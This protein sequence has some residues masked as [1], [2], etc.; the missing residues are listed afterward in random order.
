MHI[1]TVSGL[2]IFIRFGLKFPSYRFTDTL[3][4]IASS[5][6][7]RLIESNEAANK[8]YSKRLWPILVNCDR[9]V[10]VTHTVDRV[11]AAQLA[12]HRRQNIWKMKTVRSSNVSHNKAA[13][14]GNRRPI[15]AIRSSFLVI[16]WIGSVC[17]LNKIHW[18]FVICVCTSLSYVFSLFLSMF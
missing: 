2:L 5:L 1:L 17:L 9:I 15:H 11:L 4:K 7:H 16:Y 14:Y 8:N 6:G 13:H 10:N 3:N 18:T 12:K